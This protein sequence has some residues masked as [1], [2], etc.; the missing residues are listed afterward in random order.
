MLIILYFYFII[1][2]IK[3]QKQTLTCCVFVFQEGA[4]G[5]YLVT[6]FII[7]VIE[8][9]EHHQQHICVQWSAPWQGTF[10]RCL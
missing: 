5:G 4:N 8:V 6:S 2:N 7:F 10:S 1:E 3:F 9:M